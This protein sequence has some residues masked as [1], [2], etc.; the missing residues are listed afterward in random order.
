MDGASDEVDIG[1]VVLEKE[2][3]KCRM[4]ERREQ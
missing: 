2:G 1:W 3:V 4:G